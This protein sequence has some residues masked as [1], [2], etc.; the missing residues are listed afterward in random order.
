MQAK[1]KVPKA[2]VS[3]LNMEG[4]KGLILIGCHHS[5][6]QIRLVL[7]TVGDWG[8]VLSLQ[9]LRG[10]SGS[11]KENGLSFKLTMAFDRQDDFNPSSC[12]TKK[13]PQPIV[14]EI[15]VG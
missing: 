5:R 2:D 12:T 8:L 3:N 10:P 7:L 15:L 14:S 4:K 9:R 6:P 13:K 11:G 1:H